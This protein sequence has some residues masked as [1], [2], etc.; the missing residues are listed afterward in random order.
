MRAGAVPTVPRVTWSV[1]HRDQPQH[2]G[3][4]HAPQLS[5]GRSHTASL[6]AVEPFDAAAAA[7]YATIVTD[8]ASAGRPISVADTQIASICRELRA[9][10]ATRNG[11]DFE[12]TGI[13]IVDPW[14]V[15][16]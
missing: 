10:L 3:D 6:A 15:Q 9:T 5:T 11:K 12:G 4:H 8:R 14:H 2:Q 16:A 1:V 7:H 13:E